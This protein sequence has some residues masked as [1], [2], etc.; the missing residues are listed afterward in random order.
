[1]WPI[2][3]FGLLS[4]SV[5]GW[6]LTAY[7]QIRRIRVLERSHEE[8]QVEETLVFDFLHGLGEAFSDTIRPNEL[9]RLIVE[10]ATRILDAHGGALYVTDRTGGKLTPSFISK[11]CPPLVAVPP[12]ILQEAAATPIALESYLRLHSIVPGEGV[13]G[14]VWQ[15]AQPV[16]F[17]ELSQAP[18]LAKLRDSAF[19]T[20]SVMAASLSYG[21]QD[22]GVLAVANGPMGAPFSQGDFVVFKSIAEQ[23]AFALYNAIIYSMANEKKRLDHDL[24]IARDIQRIL[25]PAEAPAINGFQISGINVPARQ[26]SGDYFDYI[27]VDEDRLGVAI[28]DVSGKGVP[29]SLIMAICRSVLRAEAAGNPSPADVLRKVNRQLYPDIKEDMFIS[30]AYLILDHERDGVT[31]ARGGHD[32]PLLYKRQLQSVTPVKSP[33][34]VLGIDSGNVFDRLTAD[35]GVPLERDDCLVLYTDGV[36]EA[37]NTEGDEFGLERTIESVRASATDGAQAIVKQVIDDVRNFT[38]SNPQ[39]DDITLI[40]IRKI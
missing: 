29:A 39:N 16:C 17:N 2:L 22:L 28:A 34:M 4:A 20:A 31:L 9:H 3:L 12:D 32:A 8:I 10:G 5:A 23:S 1:M 25:L 7:L 15:T 18:E 14:R 24:E 27:H 40:A 35:F 19:G 13:I 38:G 33:G 30:M 11:G 21:K 6:I 26:V 36:T 37:L